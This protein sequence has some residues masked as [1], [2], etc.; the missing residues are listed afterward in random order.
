MTLTSLTDIFR[1]LGRASRVLPLLLPLAFCLAG[2]AS[3]EPVGAHPDDGSHAEGARTY[4]SLR[5]SVN[6]P[7]GETG[8]RA[9]GYD[10]ELPTEACELIGTLRVIVVSG[11]TGNVEVNR[12]YEFGSNGCE[13]FTT[14][15]FPVAAND[16][17]RIYLYANVDEESVTFPEGASGFAGYPVGTPYPAAMEEIRLSAPGSI[18]IDNSGERKR[19]I[20]MSESFLFETGEPLESGDAYTGEFFLTRALSKFTFQIDP[21]SDLE[22]DLRISEIT[23]HDMT[24]G[25]WLLPH[26]TTYSPEKYTPSAEKYEGRAITAFETPA[27][28]RRNDVSITLPEDALV[29]RGSDRPATA[30]SY[31]PGLYFTESAAPEKG[32]RISVKARD[33]KSMGADGEP[34]EIDLGTGVLDNLPSLPR[35]THAVVRMRLTGH[36]VKMQVD[37]VPY[38]SVVLEPGFGL[39][40]DIKKSRQQ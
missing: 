12:L 38:K 7:K 36:T 39:D 22:S 1:S 27:D 10:F 20:P 6:N 9:D 25:G 14:E 18:C 4:L 26:A 11:T 19:F 28:V 3:E 5:V 2:C 16:R 33:L 32:F 21:E 15:R 34:L 23:I 40:I 24:D 13:Q 8:T 29:W 37:L 35:N 31:S 30:P 17:K